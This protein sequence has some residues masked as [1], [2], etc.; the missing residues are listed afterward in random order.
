M[1][2]DQT[3]GDERGT[4]PEVPD[5]LDQ[6][7]K[8]VEQASDTAQQQQIQADIAVQKSLRRTQWIIAIAAV[9]GCVITGI[10]ARISWHQWKAMEAAN[11][12][13]DAALAKT[14]ESLGIATRALSETT[15]QT[16][17]AKDARENSDKAGAAQGRFNSELLRQTERSADI[18]DR[19]YREAERAKLTMGVIS[20]PTVKENEPLCVSFQLENVGHGDATDAVFSGSVVAGTISAPKP[21][22]IGPQLPMLIGPGVRKQVIGCNSGIMGKEW[23]TRFNEHTLVFACLGTV[24]YRDQFRDAHHFDFCQTFDTTQ[25]AGIW[26]DRWADCHTRES[27]N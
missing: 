14:D 4:A 19:S 13:T 12:R 23:V 2:T 9:A 20:T 7:P 16:L 24:T 15:K 26:K 22:E 5:T 18:A 8:S 21:E 3:K 27:A 10:Y 6:T 25:G 11:K 1:G 17:I